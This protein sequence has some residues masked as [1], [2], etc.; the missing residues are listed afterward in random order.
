MI[1]FH[2]GDILRKFREM[3]ELKQYE[4]ADK[5]NLRRNTISDIERRGTRDLKTLNKL[6]DALEVPLS[7]IQ[8]EYEKIRNPVPTADS[9][10]PDNNPEHISYFKEMDRILHN[11]AIG[12]EITGVAMPALKAMIEIAS[13]PTPAAIVE[14]FP[15]RRRKRIVK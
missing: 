9:I 8:Q 11:Y 15:P 14:R 13:G 7:Q 10:C 6:A 4:L 3:R 2:I 5:A 1:Q 12:E